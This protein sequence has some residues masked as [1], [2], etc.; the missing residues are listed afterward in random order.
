MCGLLFQ[1]KISGIDHSLFIDATKEMDAR[2]PDN[3]GTL[4][5][6]KYAFGHTR[7]SI[8]DLSTVANQ[9]MVSN[10]QRYV[11]IFNGEIYNYP[12]LHKKLETQGTKLLSSSDTEVL[13]QLLIQFGVSKTL[14]MVRGMFAFVFYDTESDEGIAVRDHFGQKPLYYANQNGS[15]TIASSSRPLRILGELREPNVSSYRTYLVTR[16]ILTPGETFEKGLNILPAGHILPFKNGVPGLAEKYFSPDDLIDAEQQIK[17][18]EDFDSFDFSNTLEGYLKESIRRHLVSDV[19]VGVLLSGGIDSSLLYWYAV[20]Q[21]PDLTAYTKISPGIEK[22]P[23]NNIPSILN[24]KAATTIFSLQQPHKYVQSL[25]E[26]IRVSGIVPPW[27]GGPSMNTLCEEAKFRGDKVLLGGDCADEYF[28][29]Y[30]GYQSQF[31]DFKGNIFDLGE[32]IDCD[33]KSPFF[34]RSD[35]ESFIDY[36]MS[37]RQ[38]MYDST[39]DFLP[40]KERFSQACLLHDTGV[41]LQSCTLPNSDAYSMMSSIELRNPFLDID[42]V[43]YVINL[44]IKLRYNRIDSKEFKLKSILSGLAESRIGRFMVKPKEGTR[45]YSM[46]VSDVSFWNLKNFFINELFKVDYE[47]PKKRLF[48]LICLEMFHRLHVLGEDVGLENMMTDSGKKMLL[49]S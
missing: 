24:K 3:L 30:R 21:N 26:F 4:F 16:G 39:P 2:G 25:W 41:F 35:C 46:F 13:L 20:D 40:V 22:I 32:Q 48:Q 33:E 11:L 27:G 9:P 18:V 17:Y 43:S 36:Q 8:Q 5:G 23:L 34:N 7:L 31:D 45:N 1:Y 6:T 49:S 37:Y 12:E 44:P 28:A 14:S 29:G 15:F 42:M 10:D 47:M 38:E 19:P